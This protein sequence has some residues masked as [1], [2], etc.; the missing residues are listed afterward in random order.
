MMEKPS[1]GAIK[2]G[3]GRCLSGKALKGCYLASV[4]FSMCNF[5]IKDEYLSHWITTF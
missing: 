4:V 5:L 2:Q 1:I 3:I